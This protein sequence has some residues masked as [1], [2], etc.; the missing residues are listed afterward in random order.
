M[1]T[2]LLNHGA[3]SCL[4]PGILF[5]SDI[6]TFLCFQVDPMTT[7]FNFTDV[8]LSQEPGF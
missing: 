7:V 4:A 5:A 6:R 3:L 2:F 1:P 8:N